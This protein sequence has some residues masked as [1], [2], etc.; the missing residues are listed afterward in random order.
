MK[1]AVRKSALARAKPPAAAPATSKSSAAALRFAAAGKTVLADNKALSPW[2]TRADDLGPQQGVSRQVSMESVSLRSMANQALA[3]QTLAEVSRSRRASSESLVGKA[4]AKAETMRAELRAEL[5]GEIQALEAQVNYLTDEQLRRAAELTEVRQEAAAQREAAEAARAAAAS[6]ESSAASSHLQLTAER[7]A[8]VARLEAAAAVAAQATTAAVLDAA[9]AGERAAAAEA[10]AAAAETEAAAAASSQ[11]QARGESG[12]LMQALQAAREE[13]AELLKERG[14]WQARAEQ[15][16]EAEREAALAARH[17]RQQRATEAARRATEA[18]RRAGLREQAETLQR[19]TSAEAQA[20]IAQ[21]AA[22]R[23]GA[24][25]CVQRLEA[26]C[27]E[28]QARA[29]AAEAGVAEGRR[30]NDAWRERCEGVEERLRAAVQADASMEQAMTLA[31]QRVQQLSSAAT[32]VTDLLGGAGPP[33]PHGPPHASPYAPQHAWPYAQPYA[34]PPHAPPQHAQPLHAQQHALPRWATP[35]T[36][37][38][39]A[40]LDW[41]TTAPAAAQPAARNRFS[42][43]MTPTTRTSWAAGGHV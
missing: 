15:R 5:E 21:L 9:A 3:N 38:P 7:D 16:E 41:P 39:V 20:A 40:P 28:L 33:P 35:H 12:L 11:E 37:H 23:D 2:A 1:A 29:D 31:A 17:D 26:S 18:A 34:P 43:P 22:E 25:A 14:S 27:T 32:H 8:L 19:E 10:R 42:S 4:S 6:S 36:A 24:H 30:V 13:A